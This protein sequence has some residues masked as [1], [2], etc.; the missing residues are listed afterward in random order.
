ME[1]MHPN[2][3][4]MAAIA[5]E[6]LPFS[7]DA[8]LKALDLGIGTG[9]FTLHFLGK[10]PQAKVVAVDGAEAM[11]ELAR[12]RLGSLSERVSFCLGDFRELEGL[13][14]AEQRFDVIYSSYSLHHL[15]RQDK[16]GANGQAKKR[17]KPGGWFLNADLIAEEDLA[18][19]KSIQEIR[20]AGIVQRASGRDGRFLDVAR[21]HGGSNLDC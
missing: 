20:V 14:P 9:Y 21:G 19:E 4:K 18:L 2:R 15:G 1:L 5:L 6:V 13:M 8:P 10:Y 3:S 17:L 16:V 12:H 7:V 11:M